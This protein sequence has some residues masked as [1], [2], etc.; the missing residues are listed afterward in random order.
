MNDN[1]LTVGQIARKF[2]VSARAVRHYENIGLLESKRDSGSNYRLY[3][4]AESDRLYQ[5]LLLK[6]MGFTLKETSSIITSNGNKNT[7]IKIIRDKLKSLTKKS[8]LYSQCVDLLTEFLDTCT[9]QEGESIDSFSLLSDLISNK[10]NDEAAAVLESVAAS[11]TAEFLKKDADLEILGACLSD[12]LNPLYLPF[13]LGQEDGEFLENFFVSHRRFWNL[14]NAILIDGSNLDEIYAP[15]NFN[16]VISRKLGELVWDAGIAPSGEKPSYRDIVSGFCGVLTGIEQE[17]GD[18]ISVLEV[19]LFRAVFMRGLEMLELAGRLDEKTAKAV[20]DAL[21]L[22]LENPT[23]R[24]LE[25]SI[26]AVLSAGG[27]AV[28]NAARLVN[29]AVKRNRYAGPFQVMTDPSAFDSDCWLLDRALDMAFGFIW[30]HEIEPAGKPFNTLAPLIFQ[31][32]MMRARRMYA[33]TSYIQPEIV[34]IEGFMLMGAELVT[35]ERDGRAFEEIPRFEAEAYFAEAVAENIPNRVKPGLTYGMSTRFSGE[36]YSYIIGEEVS[37]L[38]CIPEGMTG[39][40]VP[41]GNY[42]VFTVRGGPLPYKVIEMVGYIYQTYLPA[43]E[44]RWVD[45][46]G[47]NLYDVNATRRSDS[48]IKIYVPVEK[49]GEEL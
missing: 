27:K 9:S 24:Q 30:T 37:S 25:A 11:D 44:Y 15:Q 40:R 14:R 5:I 38:G 23:K 42:A 8:L 10:K 17:D 36:Y 43:S 19:R 49:R 39:E 48:V 46:P 28:Y 6:G 21:D 20:A 22:R 47:F 4:D 7:I 18:P 31:I 45:R 1:I 41:A 35:T 13:V 3:G 26:E 2:G 33:S 29:N 32:A 34:H 12:D 16:E